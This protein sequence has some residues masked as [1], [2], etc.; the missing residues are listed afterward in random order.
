MAPP[1]APERKPR[2]NGGGDRPIAA[3]LNLAPD[4]AQYEVIVPC[5]IREHGVSSIAALGGQAPTVERSAERAHAVLAEHLG[6]VYG[7]NVVHVSGNLA[8]RE[9]L[10]AELAGVGAE[11]FL[12]ELKAAAVDVVAEVALVRDVE[13]VLAANDLVSLEP[14]AD[15]DEMLLEVAKFDP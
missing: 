12:V 6:G 9:L 14:D 4:L 3:A 7:A 5:G 11:V 15:L 13:V 10:R 1:R 8:N 2:S